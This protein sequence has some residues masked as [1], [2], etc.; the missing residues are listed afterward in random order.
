MTRYFPD[1]MPSVDNSMFNNPRT[2]KSTTIPRIPQ[3]TKFRPSA[4]FVSLS[5]FRKKY[6]N[7]PQTK[8]KNAS[9]MINGITIV[10]KT[11]VMPVVPLPTNL[12]NVILVAC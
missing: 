4:R 7:T 11:P 12:A 2:E 8:T 3:N 6:W 10:I 1:A 9:A 5:L